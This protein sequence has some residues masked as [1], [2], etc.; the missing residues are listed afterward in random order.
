MDSTS[1]AGNFE[2]V[3][4][5]RV[6]SEASL[7]PIDNSI[8]AADIR[9][10]PEQHGR[11]GEE[12]QTRDFAKQDVA[13]D[14]PE[15]A[16]AGVHP[17]TTEDM[18]SSTNDIRDDVSIDSIALYDERR[19]QRLNLTVEHDEDEVTRYKQ[20][21]TKYARVAAIYTEGLESRV[22]AL[23]RELL[24]LQYKF[25]SKERPG[26]ERQVTRTIFSFPGDVGF[27]SNLAVS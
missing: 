22:G 12:S 13:P 14:S 26:E 23:E 10:Q 19:T 3:K 8:P 9:S 24:E 2:S 16:D 6:P 17:D 21:G 20:R 4:P 27:C 18:Q 11:D 7:S 15:S 1:T 25:G 5:Q